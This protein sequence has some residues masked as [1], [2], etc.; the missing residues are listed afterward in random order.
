MK[1]IGSCRSLQ[2]EIQNCLTLLIEYS[3]S[4]DV[5]RQYTLEFEGSMILIASHYM[6][7][8]IIL[9]L[10]LVSLACTQYAAAN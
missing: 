9:S 6:I 1:T 8:I 7:L 5:D 3:E 10:K 4:R 2:V